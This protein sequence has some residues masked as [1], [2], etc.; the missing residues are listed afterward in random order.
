MKKFDNT[1]VRLIIG[2]SQG[3]KIEVTGSIVEFIGDIDGVSSPK[4]KR[5]Y[6]LTLRTSER[7]SPRTWQA[8]DLLML[9]Q[10]LVIELQRIIN[11][12]LNPNKDYVNILEDTDTI[13]KLQPGY[14]QHCKKKI[15]EYYG[16]SFGVIKK[17]KHCHKLT[18]IK[19]ASW[20]AHWNEVISKTN[21]PGEE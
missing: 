17:C 2:D 15:A 3:I 5:L 4:K 9:K 21:I 7:H 18:V 11:Q 16:F 12:H 10:H 13:F 19:N 8:E 6:E 14:C 1:L 20:K